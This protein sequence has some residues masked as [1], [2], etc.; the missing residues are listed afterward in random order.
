MPKCDK[1]HNVEYGKLCAPCVGYNIDTLRAQ[2]KSSKQEAFALL[3]A[4]EGQNK[5]ASGK[6]IHENEMCGDGVC[7]G[8]EGFGLEKILKPLNLKSTIEAH[9]KE[10]EARGWFRCIE[11][12]KG[13]YLAAD[14]P[15]KRQEALANLLMTEAK[16][17][18]SIQ[19]RGEKAR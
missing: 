16:R 2:L 5:C 14:I 7:Y 10:V 4:I 1:G 8:P 13:L 19:D 11:Y 15:D 17:R 3:L 18:A 12:L 6:S 9:D